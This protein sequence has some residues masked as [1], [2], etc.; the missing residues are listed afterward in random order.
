MTTSQTTV[1]GTD[2]EVRGLTKS[3]GSFLAVDDLSFRVAPGRITGF[4]GPNGSG[5]TTTLRMLLGLIR[6]TAG[7]GLIGGRRYAEL[8][9]PLH[10][11]GAALEATNFHPGRSGRDHLRVLAGTHR[12]PDSRVDE[13]LEL[14]GIPAAARKRAGGYS[15]GMRQRLGLAGALLRHLAGE[16]KTIL[17]SSHL[18][19]E[20]ELTVDDVVIIANG[21]LVRQGTMDQ[22]HGDP[23]TLVRTPQPDQLAAALREQ[24]LTSEPQPD[25]GAD[26]LRVHT[27]DLARV[28][29]AAL[30]T[31]APVHELRPLRTDLER[32][33]FELTEAPAHRNRNLGGAEAAT[34]PSEETA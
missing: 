32:L 2:V 15:M 7:Q 5:K 17:I 20:V 4:L 10:T 8:P 6:P 16:G 26:A 29:D 33:F 14:V 1:P 12:I 27:G 24:Q 25:L 23:A 13:M 22:L 34:T 28:G 31:G 18:L 11:V 30:R 9:A 3:F 19:S 21:H